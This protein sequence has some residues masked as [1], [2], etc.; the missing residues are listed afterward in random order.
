MITETEFYEAVYIDGPLRFDG[1]RFVEF[2]CTNQHLKIEPEMFGRGIC[3]HYTRDWLLPENN[4]LSMVV[5]FAFQRAH[6]DYSFPAGPEAPEDGQ[7]YGNAGEWSHFYLLYLH[8]YRHTFSSCFQC[9]DCQPQW[10]RFI[11]S[12]ITCAAATQIR[13]E[14]IGHRGSQSLHVRNSPSPE[15]LNLAQNASETCWLPKLMEQS[16]NLQKRPDVILAL[17]FKGN[18]FSQMMTSAK[19]CCLP[20]EG[21]A[22]SYLAEHTTRLISF[23][24]PFSTEDDENRS[25]MF[26]LQLWLLNNPEMAKFNSREHLV[27]CLLYLHLYRQPLSEYFTRSTFA[28]RWDAIPFPKKEAVAADIRRNLARIRNEA[29]K[30]HPCERT[31]D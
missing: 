29:A 16:A 20:I 18:G 1:Y 23:D 27:F 11:D 21:N 22:G 17:T 4:D 14:L 31:L 3:E 15:L 26:M 30:A 12:G 13:R 9:K 28:K 6:K 24:I 8:L 25:V 2:Y 10:T 7:W 5:W 19:T